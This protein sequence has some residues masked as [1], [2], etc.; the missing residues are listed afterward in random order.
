[1]D[2]LGFAH[3][4]T[5]DHITWRD[6]PAST[7]FSAIPTLAAAAGVTSR[8]RLGTLVCTPNFRHP[9]PL[10]R[11]AMTLD[12]L[13]GGR[14]VLGLGAGADGADAGVLRADA[15]AAGE[16]AGRFRE[17]VDLIDRLLRG[18]VTRDTGRY[19]RNT[20]IHMIAG[21]DQRPRLPIAV[22]AYGPQGMALAVAHGDVWVTNGQ[23]RRPGVV[24]PVAT[25]QVVADQNSRV[26][27]ICAAHGRDPATL[28]RMLVLANRDE[29]SLSSTEFFV[30]VVGHYA[31]A[32]IT[33]LVVP[34]PRTEAPFV[35][36][37]Q[38]LER[39]AADILP[40]LVS[41]PPG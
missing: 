40:T 9:V 20:D 18:P 30:D 16:R 37:L 28:A 25:P 2:E 3:A 6:L 13:S 26:D 36:D 38:V 17:F 24:A 8:I 32:G 12:D 34:F 29:S 1:V 10:A 14:F 39:V 15:P 4:W 7:W 5:Y 21:D 35:A 33:D 27:T 11:E 41:V 22:A 31:Q 19:Y 23:S